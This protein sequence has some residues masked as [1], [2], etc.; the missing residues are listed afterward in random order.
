MNR[1][2]WLQFS[3]SALAALLLSNNTWAIEE[4]QNFEYLVSDS[5]TEPSFKSDTITFPFDWLV[6]EITTNGKDLRLNWS[7]EIKQA[8]KVFF[9]I[10]SAT[11][12][13]EECTLQLLTAK[14][15][16]EIGTLDMRFAHYMQPF[17]VLIE[18]N[19]IKIV[20]EEG[21][22]LKK[23]SGVKPLYVFTPSE[24]LEDIPVQFLP[25]LLVINSKNN[26][27]EWRNRL[28]S[29]ASISTF[30]WM[31]GCVLDGIS[32][33]KK[34][35]PN[36]KD[37]LNK[38]LEKFFANNT[39][40]YEN[41]NNKRS[42]ETIN[43]VESILPFAILAN[44]NANHV[45]LQNAIDFC[46]NHA[47]QNGVIADETETNR[48]LKTEECYTISYPLA[49]LAQKL[50]QP[51]LLNLSIA[52]LKARV[53]LL[54]T[55]K[56]IYQNAKENGNPEF[57]NWARGV[58]W[59]L[60]GL[61]KSLSV[62]P[63]NDDTQNLKNA[64]QKGVKIALKHQQKNGLWFNF[65]DQPLTG[66]DTSGSASIAAALAFGFKNNLLSIEAH[67]AAKKSWKGLQKYLT[68]DGYLRGTAQVN[69]GGE[70]LQKNG[71]R[72]ISPYTLGFM[73]ILN[74]SLK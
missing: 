67:L 11:D 12:I 25:H 13:R 61:A 21:I 64:F 73:A 8:K 58:G 23:I 48:R 59:Y 10:T 22:V 71:F 39:L 34:D 5:L 15:K 56:I 17:E 55:D 14:S 20:L 37:A 68:P 3:S 31:E 9:R 50:N 54:T 45:M 40:T 46:Y 70:A 33:L 69:K 41:L 42:V 60:L 51:K 62:L 53:N 32:I 52:N 44:T 19:L 47:D 24:K 63:V 35:E 43:T 1:R 4:L 18:E 28:M 27:E 6:S 65:L 26:S 16:K 30:G 72:V 66:I 2:N 74:H 38:H 57:G 7:R 29:L 49:V 36:A